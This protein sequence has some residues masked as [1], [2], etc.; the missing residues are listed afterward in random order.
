MDTFDE[1]PISTEESAKLIGV[2]PRTLF[3]WR[4]RGIGPRYV[5][6]TPST[7]RYR[8]GDVRAFIEA[9]IVETSA[10]A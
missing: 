6:L 5:Q 9:R 7:V 8:R 10:V 1:T 4:R 2:K 3:D